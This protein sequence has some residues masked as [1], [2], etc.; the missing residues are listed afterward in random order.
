[1]N[2]QNRAAASTSAPADNPTLHAPIDLQVLGRLL[3]DDRVAIAE[4]L[5]QFQLCCPKDAAALHAALVA[6]DNAAALRSAHR[7]KGACRMVGAEALADICE[8]IER[9]VQAGDRR[10]Q[11]AMASLERESARVGAFLQD[12]L[13]GDQTPQKSS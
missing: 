13:S 3:C 10:L 9:A 6:A 2:L 4:V 8:R 7:L 1:M 5:R 11:A 12:W